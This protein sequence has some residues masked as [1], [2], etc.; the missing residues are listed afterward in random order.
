MYFI[1]RQRAQLCPM[2]DKILNRIS[3]CMTLLIYWNTE[4]FSFEMVKI[5]K[6]NVKRSIFNKIVTRDQ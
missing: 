3:I 4:C 1:L 2:A 6:K 5:M